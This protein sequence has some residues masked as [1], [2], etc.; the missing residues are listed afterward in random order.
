MKHYPKHPEDLLADDSF[1]RWIEG[2]ASATETSGWEAWLEDDPARKD[3]VEKAKSIH[4]AFKFKEKGAPDV[5]EQLSTLTR[6][7][8][9]Y[10][11]HRHKHIHSRL[12]YVYRAAAVVVLLLSVLAVSYLF[13]TG[14]ERY[15]MAQQSP[16]MPIPA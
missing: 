9:E 16:S 13:Y 14:P 2:T 7:V 10:E 5:E 12:V 11:L 3:L 4:L 8:D 6:S 15:T 1:I